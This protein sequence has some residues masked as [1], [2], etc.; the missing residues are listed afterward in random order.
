MGE[1]FL[2][3]ARLLDCAFPDT[4][5]ILNSMQRVSGAEADANAFYLS[6]DRVHSCARFSS[7]PLMCLKIADGQIKLSAK[8][9]AG[10]A[11]I[12]IP[13]SNTASTPDA[14]FYYQPSQM[15]DFLKQASGELT[16]EIN[17]QGVLLLAVKNACCVVVP[18]KPTA[19]KPAKKSAKK[20][21]SSTAKAA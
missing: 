20:P 11:E 7:V 6:V 4:G 13:A 3:S 16:L 18:R 5:A 17:A 2:F 1:D 12:T 8:S 10:T 19:G 21:K 14:G 9:E 15:L